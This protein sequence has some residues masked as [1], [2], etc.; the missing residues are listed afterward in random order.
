MTFI[1][2]VY[3]TQK[4]KIEAEEMNLIAIQFMLILTR[5]E[6][7]TVNCPNPVYIEYT[8]KA[9]CCS[10]FPEGVVFL[11]YFV[12]DANTSCICFKF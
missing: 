6:Q 9:N 2:S 8:L 1:D 11:G 5:L 12:K 7:F 4:Q 3:Y 10:L